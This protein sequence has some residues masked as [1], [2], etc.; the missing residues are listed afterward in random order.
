M[1]RTTRATRRRRAIFRRDR[2]RC[3][4]CGRVLP[5]EQLTVDHVQPRVKNGDHS[6][7]N[8]VTA[9]LACN[10][11]KGGRAAWEFLRDRPQE[12]NNFLRYAA[13]VWKRLR[14]TVRQA[15]P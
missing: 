8:L 4:Y 6:P 15:A 13:H 7:G 9:C 5:A 1:R 10:T 2:Y 14:R 3:V 11:A 12:R